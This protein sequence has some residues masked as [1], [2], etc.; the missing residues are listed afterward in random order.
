M[1]HTETHTRDAE[2]T[3]EAPD[4]TSV[5]ATRRG[6]R[7]ELARAGQRWAFVLREDRAVVEAPAREPPAWAVEALRELGAREVVA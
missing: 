4:G 6:D 5:R 2:A 3:I 1:S 7:V